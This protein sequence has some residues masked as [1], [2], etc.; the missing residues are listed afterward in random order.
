[1]SK[2]VVMLLVAMAVSI[3]TAAGVSSA[4]EASTSS[5]LNPAPDETWMTNGIVYSVIRHGN[6]IYVGGKFSRVRSAVSGGQRFAAT[7]LARFYADSG[8]GDPTWTPDVTG[9]DMTKTHVSELA[10]VGE[11]IWVGGTFGAVDGIARRNLAAVSVDSGTV[12]PNVDPL[13]GP[14]ETAGAG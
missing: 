12:D 4:Q 8:V 13:V 3:F 7:N 6:Y 11:N 10:V 1:V 5:T 14:F 9:A 2:R